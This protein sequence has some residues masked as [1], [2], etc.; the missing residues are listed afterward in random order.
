MISEAIYSYSNYIELLK[1][2]Q[3]SKEIIQNG[4]IILNELK[5]FEA[6]VKKHANEM[7]IKREARVVYE[8]LMRSKLSEGFW[9]DIEKPMSKILADMQELTDRK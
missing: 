1:L 8:E 6:E 9:D 4:E 3:C 2:K 5:L 7:K